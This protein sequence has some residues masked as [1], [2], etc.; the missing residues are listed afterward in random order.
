MEQSV[1][2]IDQIR[3]IAAPIAKRYGAKRLSLFGSYARGD[4]TRASD[5]DLFLSGGKIRGLFQYYAF[6]NELED[7]FGR[8]VD[9]VMEGSSDQELLQNIARDEVMLYAES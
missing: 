1:L 3:A 2:T 9:V 5:V 6:V 8:H 7:A 4:E